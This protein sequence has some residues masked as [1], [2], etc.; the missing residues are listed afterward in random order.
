[1]PKASSARA[2]VAVR[3]GILITNGRDA[4]Q[5]PSAS[6]SSQSRASSRCIDAPF[7]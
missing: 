5:P 1:M 7:S 3:H 4:P 6:R 2:A